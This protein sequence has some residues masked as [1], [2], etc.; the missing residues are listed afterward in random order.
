MVRLA[1]GWQLSVNPEIPHEVIGSF[2]RPAVRAI[3][4]EMARQIGKCRLFLLTDL[5]DSDLA[6][7]WRVSPRG[8]EI[9]VATEGREGHEIALELLLCLGQAL[10]EKLTTDQLKVYWQLLDAEFQAGVKGEIDDEALTKK[11]IL[12]RNRFSAGVGGVFSDM[13]A[14]PSPELRPSM[15]TASGTM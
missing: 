1:H 14:L 4:L 11:R 12:L 8:V 9:S 13:V 3:P 15:F 2:I 5:G 7:Q 10:W 6:S